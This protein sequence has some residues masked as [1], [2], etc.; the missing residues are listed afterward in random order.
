MMKIHRSSRGDYINFLYKREAIAH[1]R[2]RPQDAPR[3]RLDWPSL[4]EATKQSISSQAETSI[5]SLRSQ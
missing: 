4:S 1:R 3:A 2:Q 5:A